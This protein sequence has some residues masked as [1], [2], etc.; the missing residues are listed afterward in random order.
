MVEMLTM[1]Q[2]LS[3]FPSES[4]KGI[5]ILDGD[6]SSLEV[7]RMQVDYYS[8]IIFIALDATAAKL[9]ITEEALRSLDVDNREP[10]LT[11]LKTVGI[12]LEKLHHKNKIVSLPS[13]LLLEVVK[14]NLLF[15]DQIRFRFNIRH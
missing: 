10:R 13:Y 14:R 3:I 11:P 12:W 7:S 8:T 2:G 15:L 6:F 1:V 5:V 9:S 4:R